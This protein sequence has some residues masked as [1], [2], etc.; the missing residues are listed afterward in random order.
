M[1]QILFKDTI[2]S[3]LNKIRKTKQFWSPLYRAYSFLRNNCFLFYF[4][5]NIIESYCPKLKQSSSHLIPYSCTKQLYNLKH[6][7]DKVH[8]VWIWHGCADRF[9]QV[10]LRSMQERMPFQLHCLFSVQAMG[11]QE[12]QWHNGKAYC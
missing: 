6:E 3:I 11:P 5:N 12:M 7:E 9:W 2:F 1:V 4:A 10:P 8:G